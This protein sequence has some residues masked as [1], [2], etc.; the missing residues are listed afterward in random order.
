MDIPAHSV[1]VGRD[2]WLY[3]GNDDG[4]FVWGEGQAVAKW[5]WKSKEF[6][7]PAPL[8][9]TAVKVRCEGTCTVRLLAD[10]KEVF[11]G[12]LRDDTP[13]RIPPYPRTTR[14]E[15]EL[16]SDNAVVDSIHFATSLSELSEG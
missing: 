8:R 13:V 15:I 14:Y 10:G 7:L 9:F 2:G 16:R 6:N 5:T 3:I 12:L 11:I 4:V 1:H